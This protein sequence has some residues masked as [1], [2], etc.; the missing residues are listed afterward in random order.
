MKI[1]KFLLLFLL[2]LQATSFTDDK[3]QTQ[4]IDKTFVWSVKGLALREQPG[5]SAK[6]IINI[7]YGQ[8]VTIISNDEPSVTMSSKIDGFLSSY[9]LEGKW[10]K[11]LYNEKEGYVFN[12]FLSTMPPF[13]ISVESA[14][15]YLKRIYGVVRVRKVK[16]KDGLEKTTTTYKNGNVSIETIYDG[17]FDTEMN[18]KILP[19]GK[20]FYLLGQSVVMMASL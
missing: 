6:R 17:C 3:K 18:L 8:S 14:E 4:K 20:L 15:D 11:I 9:K 12:G 7:P 2:F 1:F 19:T 10:V 13:N 16:G 5:I